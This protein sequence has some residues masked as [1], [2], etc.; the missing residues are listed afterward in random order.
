MYQQGGPFLAMRGPFITAAGG[1]SSAVMSP[2]AVIDGTDIDVTFTTQI[3]LLTSD[4]GSPGVVGF[5]WSIGEGVAATNWQDVAADESFNHAFSVPLATIGAVAGDVINIDPGYSLT[6]PFSTIVSGADSGAYVTPVVYVVAVDDTTP[7]ED[8]QIAMDYDYVIGPPAQVLTYRWQSSDGPSTVGTLQTYTPDASDVGFTLTARVTSTL[9]A[10]SGFDDSAATS[11]VASGSSPVVYDAFSQGSEVNGLTNSWT[12][13][14]SGA[15]SKVFILISYSNSSDS[16]SAVTYGGNAMSL[17]GTVT[18]P[19]STYVSAIYGLLSPPTGAQ[20]ASVTFGTT[21]RSRG[22]AISVTGGDTAALIRGTAT[23][24]T[25]ATTTPNVTQSSDAVDLVLAAFCS[26]DAASSPLTAG[27]STDIR[28]QGV[29]TVYN[30]GG[31]TEP[32][33]A[34]VNIGGTITGVA[35]QWGIVSCS[36]KGL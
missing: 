21:A 27:T 29:S 1:S 9:G 32:G 25:G 8:V 35:R 28:F 36:V 5:Y 11:A 33:G 23:T 6:S 34:S 2:A 24:A 15:P 19:T 16:I 22:G 18:N 4:E 14:P 10:L 26:D 20:T 30:Q 17:V 13:T 31:L 12:H 3:D 7:T